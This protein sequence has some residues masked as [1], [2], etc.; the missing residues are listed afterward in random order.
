MDHEGRVARFEQALGPHL[1]AAH[2]LARWLLRNGPDAEDAVQEACLRAFSAFH[3]FHGGD[4]RAWLL[5]IVRNVCYTSL[6]RNSGREI[7][8]PFVEDDHS[9]RIETP[10]PEALLLEKAD[11]ESIE[12][13]LERLPAELRE[14][15]V[16]RELE[17]MTYRE[18]ST[19]ADIPMG[20]VMSRLARARRRLELDLAGQV[21]Q[22]HR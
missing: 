2:N 22:E 9:G 21:K 5:A 15:V 16:L 20:T 10:T 1:D 8:A 17:G 13:A 11:R 7:D 4:G 3:T 18:I 6:R 12:G 14:V 19:V